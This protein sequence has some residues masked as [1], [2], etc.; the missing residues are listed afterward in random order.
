MTQERSERLSECC[1][2]AASSVCKKAGIALTIKAGR[3]VG[4]LTNA[5][6]IITEAQKN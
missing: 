6:I 5:D 3:V 4:V 1:I 2:H